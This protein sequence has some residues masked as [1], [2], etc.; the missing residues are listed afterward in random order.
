MVDREIEA[1]VTNSKAALRRKRLLVVDDSRTAANVLANMLE[2]LGY[3]T[4]SYHNAEDA[5]EAYR[6]AHYDALLTD[7]CLPGMSGLELLDA[8]KDLDGDAIVV[9]VTEHAEI[10]VKQACDRYELVY[11][12]RKP[13]N[14]HELG[15]IL[16]N[17]FEYRVLRRDISALQSLAV[18]LKSVGNIRD[19]DAEYRVV[20]NLA[21]DSLDA[22]M[23][24]LFLTGAD[25]RLAVR[26]AFDRSGGVC[27]D[28]AD[29][30]LPAANHVLAT[31]D[32]VISTGDGMTPTVRAGFGSLLAAP[33]IIQRKLDGVL[34]FERTPALAPFTEKDMVIAKIFATT[35][36][37]A[38][39]NLKLFTDS[40]R[41]YGELLEAQK[42]LIRLEKLASLGH[43]T[44][45]I[46]HEIKNPLTV[47]MGLIGLIKRKPSDEG[48]GRDLDMCLR[49]CD[50]INQIIKNLRNLYTPS[51]AAYRPVSLRT[52]IDEALSLTQLRSDFRGI[53]LQTDLLAE[54][55]QVS[56]D[57]SQILQVFI[58]LLNNAVQ[59]MPTGGT[60][61]V[62][63]TVEDGEALVFVRDT[64]VGIPR[65]DLPRLFDAFFTTRPSGE[66]TGLGLTISSTIVANHG[67]VIEVASE[68]GSGTIFTVRM[69]L[70]GDR[71][72][73]TTDEDG[74][75]PRVL[76]LDDET[77]I[78]Y[79]VDTLLSEAGMRVTTSDDPD[80][81]L[82]LLE[83]HE[84]DVMLIDAKM[85]AQ[86]GVALFRN[87]IAA[88]YPLMKVVLFTGSESADNDKLKSLGFFGLVEKPCNGDRLVE[89]IRRATA[90]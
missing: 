30:L 78:L 26:A 62:Q 19:R 27:K 2:D 7:L 8:V 66:G 1:A 18:G 51:Q 43:L 25:G 89:V 15:T 33:M 16:K 46:A 45:G 59:A 44:A 38:E 22:D 14:V 40:Q 4:R 57:D 53:T 24:T 29:A 36:A 71:A 11:Y 9:L 82:R 75:G 72:G 39:E 80:Q 6:S 31:Q 28:G 56:G 3:E 63:S 17:A 34:L 37:L 52:V 83:R 12:M 87:V 41:T 81:A 47:V 61:T 70:L 55:P 84:Y 79:W 58:N 21:I 23:G 68:L 20:L 88:R 65:D 32:A 5:L 86:D 64:G 50:R 74:A 49:N 90:E 73:A 60:L 69:P 77:D 54:G 67:G 85:P 10:D 48:M 42:Q 35:I 13:A 76:V